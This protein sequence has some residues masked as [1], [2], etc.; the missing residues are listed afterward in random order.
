MPSELP[1]EPLQPQAPAPPGTPRPIPELSKPSAMPSTISAPPLLRQLY[2]IS[3]GRNLFLADLAN[4]R[5]RWSLTPH[6]AL[7]CGCNWT[8]L[9]A[10]V[11]RLRQLV[12]LFPAQTFGLAL[13]TLQGAPGDWS[14][15]SC[16]CIG[17]GS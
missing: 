10:A 7:E 12:D 11:A 13:V 6:E 4:G 15:A 1:S 16:Q 3:D 5:L 8:T 9:P 17:A 14:V 2:T